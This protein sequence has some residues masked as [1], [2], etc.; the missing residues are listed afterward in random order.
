M[1][2]VR[3]KHT[4]PLGVESE[5]KVLAWTESAGITSQMPLG[6]EYATEAT[7]S[8]I[9]EKLTTEVGATW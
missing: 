2:D 6:R 7:P 3:I 9:G 1:S 5:T 8:D 4:T